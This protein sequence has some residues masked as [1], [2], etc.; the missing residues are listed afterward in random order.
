MYVHTF[1]GSENLPTFWEVKKDVL[2]Q[3]KEGTQERGKYG[4]QEKEVPSQVRVQGMFRMV[5][6]PPRRE[7]GSAWKGW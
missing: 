7:T 4:I 3:N 1:K 2:Q 6:M 5:T